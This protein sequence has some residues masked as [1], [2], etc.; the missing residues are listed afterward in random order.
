[1]NTNALSLSLSLWLR[2]LPIR[3]AGL[4]LPAVPGLMDNDFSDGQIWAL[5]SEEED[6]GQPERGG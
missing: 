5:G 4:Q 3:G 1:M 6:R 2:F